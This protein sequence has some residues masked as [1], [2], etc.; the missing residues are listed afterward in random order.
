MSGYPLRR[1]VCFVGFLGLVLGQQPLGTNWAFLVAGSKGY[2]NYRHQADVC[3]AYQIVRKFGFPEENIITMMFDDIAYNPQN[4]TPGVLINAPDGPNVYDGVHKDYVNQTCSN[5]NFLAILT[6]NK[7]AVKVSHADQ[8]PKVINSG[9]NDRVFVYFADHGGVGLVAMADGSFLYAKDL[10]EALI[11]M[12]NNKQFKELLFYMEACESGS[13]FDG[14]LPNN[15][16]VYGTTAANGHESSYAC[17]FDAV[18]GTFL[19]DAYSVHWM[20]DTEASD[21]KDET[22]DEQYEVVRNLTDSSHV[23]R[24]GQRRLGHEPLA[25]FLQYHGFKSQQPQDNGGKSQPIAASPSRPRRIVGDLVDSRDVPLQILMRRYMLSNSDDKDSL[26]T[27]MLDEMKRRDH[28]DS[29]FAKAVARL[30]PMKLADVMATY[31]PP[32]QHGCLKQAVSA[33]ESAC[34]KLDDYSLKYTR[35]IVNLCEMGVG[36]DAIVSVFLH[37]CAIAPV[38]PPIAFG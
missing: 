30:S 17:Y 27:A 6:G 26:R 29:I 31:K 22:L 3:H 25:N 8:I 12:A 4:P 1:L 19:G 9:P 21:I 24:F 32:R 2:F 5:S 38:P 11:G 37:Q 33:F 10:V 20:E 13:M 34:A 28:I 16:G 14:L 7:T 15:I 18:R 35:A 36:P 23:M